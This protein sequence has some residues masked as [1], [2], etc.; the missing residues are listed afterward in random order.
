MRTL[1]E[2]QVLA[3]EVGEYRLVQDL[4]SIQVP[5]TVQAILAARID[6][7]PPEEKRLLQTAAVIGTEV[8][9]SLLQAIA[10]LSEDALH[11]GL[12]HLQTAEFL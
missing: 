8:P 6:R 9:F 11:C 7:L 10:A 5:P 3:G 4:P 1:V 2:T 12:S